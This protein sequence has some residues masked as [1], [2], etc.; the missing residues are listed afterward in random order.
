MTNLIFIR[1]GES[2]ANKDDVCIGHTDLDLSET[3]RI[4]AKLTAEYIVKILRLT[5]YIQATL[6]EHITQ[7]RLSEIYLAYP[8]LGKKISE[9]FILDSGNIAE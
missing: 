7:P 2:V 6:K 9:R 1:H 3:G 8:L 4:Q 5:R